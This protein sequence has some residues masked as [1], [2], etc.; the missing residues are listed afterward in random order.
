MSGP[1]ASLGS[2]ADEIVVEGVSVAIHQLQNER[3]AFLLPRQ[4]LVPLLRF[5]LASSLSLFGRL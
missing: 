1:L 3:V 2:I 4:L 5:S